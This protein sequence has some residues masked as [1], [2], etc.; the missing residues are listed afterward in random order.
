MVKSPTPNLINR[1]LQNGNLLAEILVD[2]RV[3]F[4]LLPLQ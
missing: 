4:M 1:M 2:T 3:L